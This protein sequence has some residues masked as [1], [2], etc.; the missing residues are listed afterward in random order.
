MDEM[1]KKTNGEQLDLKKELQQVNE[2]KEKHERGN[3]KKQ[4]DNNIWGKIK[5]RRK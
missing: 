2:R 5:A 3:I 1:Q 4:P